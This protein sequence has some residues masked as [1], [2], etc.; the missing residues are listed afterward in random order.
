MQINI[1][2]NQCKITNLMHIYTRLLRIPPPTHTHFFEI[3]FQITLTPPPFI[4]IYISW[5]EA[6]KMFLLRKSLIKNVI[7]PPFLY[8]L[9]HV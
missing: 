4:P 5:R 7:R 2:F 8:F 3:I 9:A 6:A 1:T